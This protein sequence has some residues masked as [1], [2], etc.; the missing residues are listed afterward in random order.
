VRL[1]LFCTFTQKNDDKKVGCT[2]ID[3]VV[4]FLQKGK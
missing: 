1:F 2:F 4:A 3:G